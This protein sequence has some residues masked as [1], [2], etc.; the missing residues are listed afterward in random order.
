MYDYSHKYDK[1]YKYDLVK[2]KIK[3]LSPGV[4]VVDQIYD[5]LNIIYNAN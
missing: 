2:L 3:H 4:T 1:Y 5:I